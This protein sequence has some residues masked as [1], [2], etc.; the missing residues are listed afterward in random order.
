MIHINGENDA[1]VVVAPADGM[2]PIPHPD[3]MNGLHAVFY[4]PEFQ[5]LI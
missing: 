3:C 1:P 5:T 2:F 4:T